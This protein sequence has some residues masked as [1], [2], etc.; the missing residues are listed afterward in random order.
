MVMQSLFMKSLRDMQKSKVQF[1]S[2]L[3][4]AT[5]A[6]CIVTGIDSLWKTVELHSE[7]MY[8]AA[9]ISDL[10]V[11]VLDPTEKELWGISRIEGVEKA[12]KR[13]VLD[14]LSNLENSPTLRVY[15]VSGKGVLDRPQMI[16]GKLSSRS[17]AILDEVFARTH[18]LNT[19]DDISIKLNNKWIRFP[20]QGLALSSEHIYSVKGS[21]DTFPNPKKYGFIIINED[22]LKSVYGRKIYNQIS[23]KLSPGADITKVKTR[24]FDAVGDDLSGIVAKEDHR[25]VSNI[26]ANIQQFKLL[27]AVFSLMFFIVTAL[28]TQS[29][30]MR[31]VENQRGQIGILKALGYGK[32][33]I[34]WHYTSYGVYMGL[35]GA[36][37]GLLLGP[38]IFGKMLIPW[39]RLNFTDYRISV[40][41]SNFIISLVLILLCTGGI[42][43]YSC[44]RLLGDSPSVLL[45]IK[46][47]KEGSHILL[48]NLTGLWSRMRFSR[49]LIARNTSRNKIRLIMSILGI[50]G[51]TGLIVAAFTI[52]NMINGI[53]LQTYNVTYTYDQKI[54]LDSKADSRF[55]RNMKLDGTLQQIRETAAEII[56][57]NGERQMKLLT[58]STKESPLIHLKDVDGNPVLLPDDGAAITRKLA[59]TLKIEA[60]D[61]IELKRTNK[62]Y[63]KVPVRQ[64]VYLATGQGIYMTDTY[65]EAIGEIFKPT[66][67]LV[68]W[69]NGPDWDFLR[70]DYVEEYVSRTD[71][72]ADVKSST[73]VVYI[74]G[75]MLIIMGGIL[76]FVVLYNSSIL[77]FAERIRDLTTLKVLG[78]YQ[79]EIRS[80][81]LTDNT[82]SVIVGLILGMPVGKAL[83][84]IVAKGLND[85]MDLIGNVS[86]G[87][88]VFSVAITAVFA[89]FINSIV[90]VK[91]KG[92]DMLESLK[93]VE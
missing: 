16:E 63:I 24:I 78:F 48:E 29:T 49:R 81:V 28:I 84:E 21:T 12:E 54:L 80:L 44:F 36:F 75:V 83:A 27:A 51:C 20:I 26:D 76:A 4:M 22:M 86:F 39:L 72:I 15:A 32:K 17:G 74:A 45:R 25:S 50:T 82:L 40:N 46:P 68:K 53:A 18:G 91:M 92:M 37:L 88:V 2:I 42:S 61:V 73:R 7:N 90:A 10:W 59:D 14:A 41:Y 43:L 66:A 30:M 13:F 70:G 71:Q 11:N 38:I 23:V 79:K 69:N 89:M 58:V 60:G 52:I 19:G 93:S 62:G 9:N 67:I 34:L 1:L 77:N 57:P 8:A 31:M 55:I 64:I 5:L 85:Q 47:P 3:I 87:T 35:L 33:S 65:Y 56:C 6:V